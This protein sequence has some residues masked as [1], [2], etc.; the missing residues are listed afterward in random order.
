MGTMLDREQILKALQAKSLTVEEA[1]RQLAEL[2]RGAARRVSEAGEPSA[3]APAR[4]SGPTRTRIAVVGMSGRY[5][6]AENLRQY[7]R[8]LSAGRNSIREVPPERWSVEEYFD[9]RRAQR[10]KVYCKWLG[11]LDDIDRFDPLFFKISPSEA[12]YIDPQHRIFLEEAYRAFEDAGYA[13]RSL[14]GSKCGV[15]L[16]IMSNEY[17]MMLAKS[18]AEIINAT[19]N[20]FSIAAARISYHL[21]LKGPAIP[22]DTACSSSLVATHLAC[23]AL[24]AGEIDLALVGGVSLYLTAESYVAM[25]GAG[26][27]SADGQCKAFDNSADGFVPGEG[28]GALVLKRLAEAERDGDDIYGVIIGTG[29]NQDG[30]TNGMTAPS[31]TSQSDLIREVYARNG[32]DPGDISYCEMHGTG[33]KLGDPVELKAL[34]DVFRP[35]RAERRYCAIG[36][37][38]S[39]I[40]HTS[41][42][43]GVASVQKVLLSMRHETLVPSLHFRTPN[44]HFDFEQSPFYVNTKAQP[45]PAAGTEPRRASISSFGISGTNAHVVIEEYV[46]RVR[47]GGDGETTTAARPLLFVLSAQSEAQLLESAAEL[48]SFVRSEPEISLPDLAYTLQVGRD[49]M[50]HR[51]AVVADSAAALVDALQAAVNHDA[52]ANVLS[53]SVQTAQAM[54]SSEEAHTLAETYLASGRW[55]ELGR[56]WVSGF[57]VD[58]EG[59]YAQSGLRR[60]RLHLPT[61]PFAREHYWL[62]GRPPLRAAK[63][64]DARTTVYVV[65]GWE[66]APVEASAPARGQT[67]ILSTRSTEQFA[68]RLKR[69]LLDA[70]VVNLEDEPDASAWPDLAGLIDITGC[71]DAPL[72]TWPWM[73]LLQQL[74]QRRGAVLLGVTLGLEPFKLERAG[75]AG[76]MQAGLYRVLRREYTALRARH[77]DLEPTPDVDALAAQI[78]REYHSDTRDTDCCYRGGRRYRARLEEVEDASPD[79]ARE[80]FVFGPEDVLWVTGGTR[81]LGLLCAKHMVESYGVKRLL[82]S[83]REELPP[84]ELWP[85]LRRKDDATARKIAGIESLEASGARVSLSSVP[86]TDAAAL[87]AEMRRVRAEHG[88]VAGVLHCAGLSDWTEPA[89]FAKTGATIERVLAPKTAGLDGIAA[90]LAGMPLQFFVLFS[91]VAAIVPS[92]GA[93]Q[94]DYAVANAYMDYFAQARAAELPIVSIQWPNWKESGMGEVRSRAYERSGLLSLTDAEGLACLDRILR[95]RMGPVVMPAVIN[96]QS[97]RPEELLKSDGPRADVRRT[98]VEDPPLVSATSDEPAGHA[99]RHEAAA[100]EDLTAATQ[101]WLVT[102]FSRELKIAA[103]KLRLDTPFQDYGVDSIMLTQMMRPLNQWADAP[104]EPSLLFEHSTI[105]A[106]SDWLLTHQRRLM[107]R[108][109]AVRQGDDRGLEAPARAGAER[110]ETDEAMA[111]RVPSSSVARGACD[112][113]VVGLS[114]RFPGAPTV[115]DYWRLLAEGRGAIARVPATRWGYD[116]PFFA[117]LLSDIE[118][119]DPA[120]FHIDE[121]DARAMDPQALMLLE[122]CAELFHH[123]GYRLDELKGQS[124]GVFV[125]GRSRHEPGRELLSRARNPV[126]VVGQNYLAANLSHFFDLHGP[127][128]VLDTACS[129]A[130][131]AMHMAVQSLAS[132]ETAAAVVG[133]VSLLESDGG[134]RMFDRRGLLAQDGEFHVFDQ[135][136]QGIVPG[137]GVG[138]VMLKTLERAYADGDQVYAVIK[139][140][141]VNNDGRTAGPASPNFQAQKDV[142]LAALRQSGKRPEEISYVEANGS[143]SVVTDLLELKAIE[144]VYRA[145][146]SRPCGLGATKPNIGHPL[147]A[148]GIASFIKVVLML[149]HR[150]EVPF[151]S[152]E[153]PLVHYPLEDSPFY[154]SRTLSPL[155]GPLPVAALNCFADGGTNAHLIIEAS[156]QAVDARRHPL[157]PPSL[158]R[159]KVFDA[160][161]KRAEAHAPTRDSDAG[162]N[163]H[164]HGNVWKRYSAAGD[165]NGNVWKRGTRGA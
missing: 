155:S 130:L 5:P 133:G 106:L 127:S 69:E 45:W 85:E 13:G 58:W 23:Q 31:G 50:G 105:R 120:F 159:H 12:E 75:L 132:D 125:G 115:A 112:I 88:P 148:E 63:A 39:N 96:P 143:G 77:V 33:T 109:L 6:Q 121:Q 110:S 97:W 123:A 53:G 151:L 102:V 11:A 38:K 146:S 54:P 90:A 67:I 91:S 99:E 81:G 20:S 32:I 66:P 60:R 9:T 30:K 26:M 157:A 111:A 101:Q 19:G 104:L 7:W 93:G 18:D 46:R 98:I 140:S 92:L 149:H 8:N 70:V 80:S 108:A 65:K 94:I 44:E 142:L 59:W 124:I 163:G 16:G 131:I 4:E 42:A 119:Y 48:R 15:Y 14:G 84:R 71:A 134:H 21:N 43:A 135:R 68:A 34:A 160:R 95:E 164:G 86:L 83:G 154:F 3:A 57:D 89:F 47:Q 156:A 153:R 10:G 17:A 24:N 78:V 165:G 113:A 55:L 129:S 107:M 73:R 29:T 100:V 56:L 49:A 158:R 22:L 137:E 138:L 40:G 51:L 27:L 152:G 28:A 37:V 126:V 82:L 141:A 61:Y 116:S 162:G 118:S 87:S 139:G 117:G 72:A 2:K 150:Q 74:A 64:A 144:A 147:C 128:L 136:A 79:A 41:A 145:Q 62:P 25:C 114:C 103:E 36:S 76:A 35:A 122:S 1:M 52:R 161:G